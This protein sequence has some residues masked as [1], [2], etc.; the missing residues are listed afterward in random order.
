MPNSSNLALMQEQKEPWERGWIFPRIVTP[1]SVRQ[2]ANQSLA[3]SEFLEPTHPTGHLH[4]KFIMAARWTSEG[5]FGCHNPK[6]KQ[7]QKRGC[8]RRNLNWTK[9]PAKRTQHFYSAPFNMAEFAKLS[10]LG[11]PSPLNAVQWWWTILNGVQ[12]SLIDNK[13]TTKLHSAMLDDV[14]SVWPRP[15]ER[16]METFTFLSTGI[17]NK[18]FNK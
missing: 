8:F 15:V 1:A 7:K 3:L 9:D 6:Q 11:H 4:V 17:C 2:F 18:H 13:V 5:H 16:S 12:Q 14:E 10:A